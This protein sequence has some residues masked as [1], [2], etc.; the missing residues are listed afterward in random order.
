MVSVFQEGQKTP[1]DV[2]K[3]LAE[4][5]TYDF[6]IEDVHDIPTLV[7]LIVQQLRERVHKA[8]VYCDQNKQALVDK[9]DQENFDCTYI[10]NFSHIIGSLSEKGDNLRIRLEKNSSVF[11]IS[12][13]R[14]PSFGCTIE[15]LSDNHP[16][17]RNGKNY[18]M[19]SSIWKTSL[20]KKGF[21][22]FCDWKYGKD[23]LGFEVGS[24]DAPLYSTATPEL[25]ELFHKILEALLL[26]R[27]QSPYADLEANQVG[28]SSLTMFEFAKSNIK[29]SNFL[30]YLETDTTE[31]SSGL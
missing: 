6:T 21:E 11:T 7:K 8:N 9:G 25:Q 20:E 29:M 2:N 14:Y 15:I 17:K 13:H 16:E 12:H 23:E 5:Q 27:P 26:Y 1:L 30:K 18:A 10:K 24:K 28:R 31:V 22:E 4:G 3:P 19:Y